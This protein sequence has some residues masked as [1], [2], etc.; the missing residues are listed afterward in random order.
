MA[1]FSWGTEPSL[2]VAF[3]QGNSLGRTHDVLGNVGVVGQDLANHPWI[4]CA[5]FLR[6]VDVIQDVDGSDLRASRT[7]PALW[8]AVPH[9]RKCSCVLGHTSPALSAASWTCWISSRVSARPASPRGNAYPHS[10]PGVNTGGG[11]QVGQDIDHIDLRVVD[12]VLGGTVDLATELLALSS[13]VAR[14]RFR[15]P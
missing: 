6:V 12:Q 10:R 2:I 5:N 13:A 8:S 7:R 4:T 1:M 11:S 9:L 14:V 15:A 3:M